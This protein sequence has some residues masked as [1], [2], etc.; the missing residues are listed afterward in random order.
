MPAEVCQKMPRTRGYDP[1]E[2]LRC[3]HDGRCH[4]RTHARSLGSRPAGF[5]HCFMRIRSRRCGV[6]GRRPSRIT[7]AMRT[8]G[9]SRPGAS[10][11]HRPA[12]QHPRVISRQQADWGGVAGCVRQ[13][14]ANGGRPGFAAG[15]RRDRLSDT[16][17]IRQRRAHVFPDRRSTT[18]A[19][20]TAAASTAG[21]Q[22]RCYNG[23]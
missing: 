2:P 5:P 6:W 14:Y 11:M 17:R 10:R 7:G 16:G 18:P 4:D 21:A 23:L 3:D 13:Q 19:A 9:R 1:C 8:W 22:E 12:D 15:A 20:S